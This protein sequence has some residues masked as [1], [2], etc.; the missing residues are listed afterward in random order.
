[1]IL[2]PT[3]NFE[4]FN[5]IIHN[6]LKV[7]VYGD[8]I[9]IGDFIEL[10][11]PKY[12]YREQFLKCENIFDD[13]Y[14]WTEDDFYHEL[15]AFHEVVLYYFIEYMGDLRSDEDNFDKIYFNKK[16]INLIEK[17]SNFDFE[18]YNDMSIE[19]YKDGYFDVHSYIDF[20]FEDIDFLSITKLYNKR[21]L[22]DTFLEDYLGINI[23]YYFEILPLDIQNKYKTNHLT[24]L[25]DVSEFLSYID[26]KVKY[27]SLYKLFWE[28]DS[29]VNEN[30][31]QII[32]DNIMDAYFH[33]KD[34]DITREALLGTGKVDFKLYKNKLEDEKI[35][36]EVK[37]ANST[38]IKKG[39]E[40]QLT[41]YML[42][43][44]YKN[45]F[46]LIACFTDDEV[47]KIE[48]FIKNHV[49]TDTIQ[50]YINISILD[51]RNRKSASAL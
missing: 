12:L 30:K 49:Y 2:F 36:I 46:Y 34:I 40:K 42:S 17:A 31:I 24:L 1:M 29:P 35:L 39:Y 8:D 26:H 11:L 51:L 10:I 22:G 47:N 3:E 44:K 15:T 4:L 14:Y 19:E 38:Y 28:N 23:D 25:G 48:Q 13:L 20:L 9:D 33:N 27:G 45:S 6:F 21:R 37:K 41:D 5:F 18:N 16:I 7:E 32:L 50:L 43:S